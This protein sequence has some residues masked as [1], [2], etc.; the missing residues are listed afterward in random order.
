MQ[1]NTLCAVAV[2]LLRIMCSFIVVFTESA[3]INYSLAILDSIFAA[4]LLFN[5]GGS[6]ICISHH[7]I[8]S[9]SAK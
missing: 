3:L 5:V 6:G 4:K 1:F 8:N 9:A 2:A 7:P